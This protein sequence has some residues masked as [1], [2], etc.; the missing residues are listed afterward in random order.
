M[1]VYSGSFKPKGFGVKRYVKLYKNDIAVVSD[2]KISK[3][4]LQ[5]IKNYII[6]ISKDKLLNKS[7]LDINSYGCF[8]E[9]EI[10]SQI[11]EILFAKNNTLSLNDMSGYAAKA[12][13]KYIRNFS[14]VRIYGNKI[15]N[16]IQ[17]QLYRKNGVCIIIARERIDNATDTNVIL[18]TAKNTAYLNDIIYV[19]FLDMLRHYGTSWEETDKFIS[20]VSQCKNP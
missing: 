14:S 7:H 1:I 8:G 9:A 19:S 4:K 15:Y 5:K 18:K 12:V 17:E 6:A 20:M 13:K 11:C 3:G 16:D 10:I 2:R